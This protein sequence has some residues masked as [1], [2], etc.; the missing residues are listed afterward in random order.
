VADSLTC[1]ALELIN[2]AARLRR[3]PAL[4][5]HGAEFQHSAQL[6]SILPAVVHEAH[7]SNDPIGAMP[8]AC[9]GALMGW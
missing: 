8:G 6:T 2:R 9:V 3:T 5:G 4:A 7:P 1:W